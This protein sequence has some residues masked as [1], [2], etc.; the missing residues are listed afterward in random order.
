MNKKY[1][2]LVVVI[3]VFCTL[4]IQAQSSDYCNERINSDPNLVSCSSWTSTST[5]VQHMNCDIWV[6]YQYRTCQV[7]VPGCGI[8][9]IVQIQT[10]GIDWNWE[11]CSWLMQVL[12]P[13]YP[14]NFSQLNEVAFANLFNSINEIL[15]TNFFNNYYNGLSQNE[16]QNLQCAGTPPNC[17]DP[18]P[19]GC[20]LYSVSSANPV[21]YKVCWGIKNGS[22][23]SDLPRIAF[24]WFPCDTQEEICCTTYRYF[25]KCG[26]DIR[27]TT[28]TTVEGDCLEAVEPATQC[29]EFTGYDMQFSQE[30]I[31]MCQ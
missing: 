18:D 30:C 29:P 5:T 20:N 24:V 6:Y 19:Q 8:K 25:C 21:C 14:N 3:I 28:V 10:T 2:H 17:L 16:Q 15:A 31:P 26:N 27:I 23:P 7:N 11:Q 4:K 12:F 9:T 22:G 13:G 1:I